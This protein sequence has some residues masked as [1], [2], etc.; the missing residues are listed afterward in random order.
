MDQLEGPFKEL[1][2]HDLKPLLTLS[3][4]LCLNKQH[5]EREKRVH[6]QT[7]LNPQCQSS[8]LV[9]EQYQQESA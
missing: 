5:T 4:N 7:A 2:R 1:L 8:D 3:S 9:R 6:C